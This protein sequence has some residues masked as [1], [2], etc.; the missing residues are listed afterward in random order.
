MP[1]TT[2]SSKRQSGGLPDT[3]Q[4]RALPRGPLL[5]YLECP[6][7]QP[8]WAQATN[9]SAIGIELLLARAPELGKALLVQ[10]SRVPRWTPRRA[11]LGWPV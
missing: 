9:L 4:L 7:F 3:K 1:V 2:V 5:R 11:W 8:H 10:L 6:S